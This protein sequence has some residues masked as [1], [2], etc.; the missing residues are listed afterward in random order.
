MALSNY[1]GQAFRNGEHWHDGC[2]ITLDSP[3]DRWGEYFHALVGDG[4]VRVGVR[5]TYALLAVR[6][7]GEWS[8]S[9]LEGR[10][11]VDGHVAVAADTPGPGAAVLVDPDGTVWTA[12][13]AY[14][15]W[16]NWCEVET[17]GGA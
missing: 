6:R 8:V 9:H 13:G 3:G 5:K 16:E 12:I 2:G 7:D 17:G 10:V 1:E 15:A 11:E 14:E 4:D